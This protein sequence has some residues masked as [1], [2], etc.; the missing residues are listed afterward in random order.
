MSCDLSFDCISCCSGFIP[1]PD[2]KEVVFFFAEIN[3]KV[4]I[5]VAYLVFGPVE[6][7]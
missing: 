5:R 6:F 4:K 7:E 3:L 2:V 1:A